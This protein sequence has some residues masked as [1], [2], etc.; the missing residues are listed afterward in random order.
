MAGGTS[1]PLHLHPL[2]DIKASG[3]LRRP[4]VVLR[5]SKTGSLRTRTTGLADGVA[6]LL[7]HRPH[8]RCPS[9]RVAISTVEEEEAVT[10]EVAEATTIGAVGG[11]HSPGREARE[12]R[13]TLRSSEG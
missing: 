1:L 9:S 3:R 4:Q 5:N 2:G 12:R 8:L 6:F 7:H 10:G 13:E 11:S